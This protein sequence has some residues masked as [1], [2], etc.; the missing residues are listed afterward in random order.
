MKKKEFYV[1]PETCVRTIDLFQP[2]AVSGQSG[3]V[4]D[5]EYIEFDQE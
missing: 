4:E 3:T 1:T 5:Y 2:I